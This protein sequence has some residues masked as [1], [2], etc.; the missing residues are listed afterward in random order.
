MNYFFFLY[1]SLSMFFFVPCDFSHALV[2]HH[3]YYNVALVSA[4]S[5][6]EVIGA[7]G[8]MEL[9]M[10]DVCEGWTIEQQSE[11]TLSL[12]EAAVEV[13]SSHYV[14]WESKGGNQLRFYANRA[15]NGITAENIKG[16]ANFDVDGGES[17]IEFQKPEVL[18][19]SMAPGTVPPLKHLMRLLNAAKTG[20]DMVSS[21]VFDGSSFG[22]SVHIDTF[23]AKQKP[24]CSIKKMKDLK[25]PVYPMQLAVYGIEAKEALPN[26]EIQ[27]NF[28]PNGVM[29][30]YTVNFGNFKVKGTLQQVDYLPQASCQRIKS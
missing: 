28:Y 14:A 23:I 17:H 22:N 24:Y 26:L 5:K 3:A 6:S 8:T 7:E 2:P 19:V 16:E 20:H 9:K 29:C 1:A 15:L 13:M 11:T 12:R 18:R 21:D 4:N 25:G 27:Q 30:S 10:A